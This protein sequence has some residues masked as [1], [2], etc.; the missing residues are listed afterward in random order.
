VGAQAKR[1]AN[2]NAGLKRRGVGKTYF[3]TVLGP[4]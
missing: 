1:L 4:P 2:I 3:V